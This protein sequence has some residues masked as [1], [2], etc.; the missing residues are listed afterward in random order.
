MGSTAV[1]TAR[2]SPW[3]HEHVG[4]LGDGPL[5]VEVVAGGASNLT[6][7][8]TGGDRRVVVRRPPEGS[9]LPTAHDVLREHRILSALHGTAVPVPEPLAACDDLDVLGVPFYVMA[10]VD[11]VIPHGPDVLDGASA[12]TNRR[13]ADA[14][15][16]VLAALH[17]TDVDA[18]GLG[19]LAKRH[20]YLERQI[21]RWTDQWARSRLADAPAIDELADVLARRLPAQVETTLVHGDYRLGNVILDRHDT[22]RVLAV[23]DWEMATLGDPRTDLGY[24]LLWW[25]ST[26]RPATHPS[27]AV[28]DLPGFPSPAE[29]VSTYERGTGRDCGDVAWF[30]ALAAFKLAVIGEGQRARLLRTGGDVTGP[31]SSEPLATWALHLLG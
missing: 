28:A 21:A 29:L 2:L 26:D 7:I 31:Q 14:Y 6:L 10:H 30:V 17:A 27:Q 5:G 13:T 4:G 22:G 25:G 24:A 16:E 15:V 1:D 11:G 8:V 19:G 3:L 20:G 9:F 23:L 18:V 12:A